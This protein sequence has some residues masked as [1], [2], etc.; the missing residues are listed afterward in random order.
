[1]RKWLLFSFA[2]LVLYG[3]G[4]LYKEVGPLVYGLISLLTLS[5]PLLLKLGFWKK[6]LALLPLLLLR[7]I[8][9]NILFLF[10][11]NALTVLMR[12]YG[13]IEKRWR[14]LLI[15][16]DDWREIG[17]SRWKT[18]KPANQAY[19]ILIFLPVALAICALI[20]LLEIV[21]LK[22][23]QLAVEKF[24]DRGIGKS[25]SWVSENKHLEKNTPDNS[26][27]QSP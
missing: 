20:I 14:T 3:S 19:L 22:A 7:V 13:L 10:G 21:R 1:M 24:L 17:V 5:L 2:T 11:R 15:A 8:G 25:I 26:S 6:I 9:K 18:T 12:R 4:F 16:I 23:V 27:K